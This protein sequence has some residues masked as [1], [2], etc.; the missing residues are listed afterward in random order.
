MIFKEQKVQ[1]EIQFSLFKLTNPNHIHIPQTSFIDFIIP[2]K[3]TKQPKNLKVRYVPLW[4]V[5]LLWLPD[6]HLVGLLLLIRTG[7]EKKM[8]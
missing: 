3:T 1:L 8:G 2:V 7:G 5:H 4:W 6:S